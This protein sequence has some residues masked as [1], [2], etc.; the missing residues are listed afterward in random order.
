MRFKTVGNKYDAAFIVVRNSSAADIPLGAP[1]FFTMN[2]TNDGLDIIGANAAAGAK[3]EL[4]AGIVAAPSGP[5]LSVIAASG[6]GEAQVFGLCQNTRVVTATR[7]ASTDTYNS[8][9]AIVVGDVMQIN[10]LSGADAISRSA[11]GA[12][13]AILP[14]II[15]AQAYTSTA[16]Q[17][18]SFDTTSRTAIV[19]SL[20]T[21]IRAM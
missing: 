5:N 4:F 12:A 15:A 14:N 13:T 21:F 8:F 3:Q 11:A 1:V 20:K 19:T 9:T 10:T 7:T 16:S 17:S 2:G 6:Y 18:S